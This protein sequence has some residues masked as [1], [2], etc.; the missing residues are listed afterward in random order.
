MINGNKSLFVLLSAL[1]MIASSA[2]GS[3]IL[4]QGVSEANGSKFNYSVIDLGSNGR[5]IEVIHNPE[6]YDG[7]LAEMSFRDRHL[8]VFGMV[9]K[10]I[11]SNCPNGVDSLGNIYVSKD[12]EQ[13]EDP[14]AEHPK[15]FSWEYIC[16]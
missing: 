14:E 7:L 2:R 16:K 11:Q 8:Q 1:L 15:Y 3:D 6:K 9:A 5:R 12:P 10:L 4:A 13:D